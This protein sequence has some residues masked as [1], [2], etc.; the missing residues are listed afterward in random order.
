MTKDS[1]ELENAKPTRTITAEDLAQ[2]TPILTNYLRKFV[3]PNE[4]DDALQTVMARALENLDKYRGDS[5]PRVWLLGIARNVGFEQGRRRQKAPLLASQTE[6]DTQGDR[7]IA[8]ADEGPAVDEVMGRKEEQAFA[9]QALGNL[10]LDDKLVLL[11]TYVDGVSGPEAAEVLG[12]S[13]S[14][15]RQ[16]L[17]RARQALRAELKS[18]TDRGDPAEAAKIL[19]AWQPALDPHG[20]KKDLNDPSNDSES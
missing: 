17:S 12:M 16:R 13:F 15:F 5:T 6:E 18:I 9:L 20:S 3:R 8:D 11:V 4:L 1:E 19:A 7:G 2:H 14:A 10:S